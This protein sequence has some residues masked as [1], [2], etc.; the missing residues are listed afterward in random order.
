MLY[1]IL[2]LNIV[3]LVFLLIGIKELENGSKLRYKW[4]IY[5]VV[6][7]LTINVLWIYNNAK[8]QSSHNEI[9]YNL[10]RLTSNSINQVR[11]IA[12]EETSS[13]EDIIVINQKI[14]GIFSHTHIL[15]MQFENLRF[16]SRNQNRQLHVIVNDLSEQLGIFLKYHNGI[17]ARGEE[18][19]VE[20]FA[21]YDQLKLDLLYFEQKFWIGGSTTS[22]FFGIDQR[23]LNIDDGNIIRLQKITEDISEIIRNL[24]SES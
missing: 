5:L 3:I 14:E 6:A 15:L 9:A 20:K 12:Y 10:H 23:R 19:P 16:V 24:T 4:T 8:V 11:Q 7:L 1:F 22:N 18:I 13:M 2:F 17:I 21:M